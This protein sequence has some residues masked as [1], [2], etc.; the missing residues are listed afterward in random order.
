MKIILSV[1]L[2]SCSFFSNVGFSESP[3]SFPQAK[4]IAAKIFAANPQT[5][6]CQCHFDEKKWIDL[7]SCQMQSA[8]AMKRSHRVE[9]EHMLRRFGN[10]L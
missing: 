9:W 2:L 10:M 4:K 5:L 3:V 6:Y 1:F 8:Q 7:N